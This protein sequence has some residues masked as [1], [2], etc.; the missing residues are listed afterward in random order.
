MP[1]SAGIALRVRPRSLQCF[2]G[3]ERV[4]CHLTTLIKPAQKALL[5]ISIVMDIYSVSKTICHFKIAE[6]YNI[7]LLGEPAVSAMYPQKIGA[8]KT[9]D[10]L[11]VS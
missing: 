4:R 3:A 6:I 9:T 5:L 10:T 1:A 7:P 11:N 8:L 2:L